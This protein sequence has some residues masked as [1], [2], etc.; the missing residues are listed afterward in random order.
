MYKTKSPRCYGRSF[1]SLKQI[2]VTIV[3]NVRLLCH[4]VRLVYQSFI[5]N[6][7]AVGSGKGGVG[8]SNNRRFIGRRFG[9]QWSQGRIDGC[10][11]FGPSVPHLFGMKGQPDQANGA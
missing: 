10:D 6:I 2:D 9:T 3:P 7:I 8:K 4:W 11:V 1:Q 5:S